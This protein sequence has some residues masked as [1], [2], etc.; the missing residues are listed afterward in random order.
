LNFPGG[1]Q[2]TIRT[3]PIFPG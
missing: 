1:G 3:D 2:N